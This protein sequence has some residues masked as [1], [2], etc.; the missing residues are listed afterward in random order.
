MSEQTLIRIN[1]QLC[2]SDRGCSDVNLNMTQAEAFKIYQLAPSSKG[3]KVDYSQY[4]EFWAV[5]FSATLSLWLIAY[6]VGRLL[7]FLK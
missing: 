1:A 3:E 7:K 2:V 6:F 5:S 4:K